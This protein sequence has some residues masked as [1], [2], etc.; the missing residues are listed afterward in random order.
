MVTYANISVD[1]P[2]DGQPYCTNRALTTTETDLGAP[3]AVLYHH[4]LI[5]TVFFQANPGAVSPT[6]VVLQSTVDGGQTWFDLAGVL[7]T[8]IS[9]QAL[10]LLSAGTPRESVAQEQTRTAGTAPGAS[11]ANQL[12]LGGQ[13]RFVG[14]T[15]AGGGGGSSSPGPDP[16][17]VTINYKM[18]GLR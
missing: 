15:G 16:L 17:R 3:Q 9:G 6:Y 1:T 11:F 10:F 14:K 12:P 13:V 2:P 4:S 8:G 5:A 7:W 18:E